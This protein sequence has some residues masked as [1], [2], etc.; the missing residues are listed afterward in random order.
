MR[1]AIYHE[2]SITVSAKQ[3]GE[4]GLWFPDIEITSAAG[5]QSHHLIH[6]AC[7][8]KRDEAEERGLTMAIEWIDRN[9]ASHQKISSGRGQL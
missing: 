2:F 5:K 7:F 6:S 9:T 1:G 8:N 4:C 3:N